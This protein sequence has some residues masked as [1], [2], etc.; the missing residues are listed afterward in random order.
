MKKMCHSSEF[1]ILK[2]A[3]AMIDVKFSDKRKIQE[4]IGISS[5]V[6]LNII[7]PRN[8]QLHTNNMLWELLSVK[9]QCLLS[10]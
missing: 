1:T 6:I 5:K 8:F 2:G 7:T 4:F 10:Q 3:V 9:M